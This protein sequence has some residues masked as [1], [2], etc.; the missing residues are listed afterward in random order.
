MMAEDNK[1][2]H[3]VVFC[4]ESIFNISFYYNKHYNSG[5]NMITTVIGH[6]NSFIFHI[7][8]GISVCVLRGE[9]SC[10]HAVRVL[11]ISTF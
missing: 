7:L 11:I 10:S 5:I 4:F 6:L 9:N 1:H 8:S 3:V 2:R